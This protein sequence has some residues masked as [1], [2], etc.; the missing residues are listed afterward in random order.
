MSGVIDVYSYLNKNI[1]NFKIIEFLYF[2][3]Y[4]KSRQPIYRVLCMNCNKESKVGLWTIKKARNGRCIH[5]KKNHCEL[6][7]GEAAINSIFRSY[8][9]TAKNR[10]YNFDLTK[11]NFLEIINKNCYYCN[12]QPNNKARNQNRTGNY[13]Y[14]GIDRLDNKKGYIEGNVVPCCINCN[15]SK[16]DRTIDD[17]KKWIKDIYLNLE[18]VSCE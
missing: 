17:F 6:P 15:R 12:A 16:S 9:R 11:N 10:E 13:Y 1:D 7:S 14:N 18:C 2:K 5:C 3:N 4:S 8:Q